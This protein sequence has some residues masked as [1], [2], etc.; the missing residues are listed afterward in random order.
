[1]SK[2]P[3][4]ADSKE[5]FKKYQTLRILCE[6]RSLECTSE[7]GLDDETFKSMP[8]GLYKQHKPDLSAIDFIQH[9][10]EVIHGSIKIMNV[11][12]SQNLI[13]K[14]RQNVYRSCKQEHLKASRSSTS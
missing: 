8:K 9:M 3:W 5:A 10:Q 4:S 12:A 6:D 1:M 2:R 7:F 11:C 13:C 14:F